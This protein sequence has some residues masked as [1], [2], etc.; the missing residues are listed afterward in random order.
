M[1]DIKRYQK[2]STLPVFVGY[3]YENMMK[4]TKKRERKADE[5]EKLARN[6]RNGRKPTDREEFHAKRK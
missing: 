6:E 2:M 1:L 4:R 3:T 5:N